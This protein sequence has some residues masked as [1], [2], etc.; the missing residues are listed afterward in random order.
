VGK[1]KISYKITK[2]VIEFLMYPDRVI[3]RN[4][5]EFSTRFLGASGFI[6]T[7]NY[8]LLKFVVLHL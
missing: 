1:L 2:V 3:N 5:I 4:R 6:I 8:G 7:E